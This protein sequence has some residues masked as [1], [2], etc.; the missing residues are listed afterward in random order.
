MGTVTVVCK[1]ANGIYLD[2]R[3][4]AGGLKKRVRING[5]NDA[6]SIAGSGYGLTEVPADHWA[7]WLRVNSSL[8]MIQNQVVFAREKKSEAKAEAKDTGPSGQERLDPAKPL[9]GVKAA[10][11]N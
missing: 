10:D 6:N 4:D 8:D 2:L 3:D 5:Y 11:S 1:L 9:R 7:E